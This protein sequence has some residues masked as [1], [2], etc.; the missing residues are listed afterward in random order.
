MNICL[1]FIILFSAINLIETTQLLP[2]LDIPASDIIVNVDK[3]FMLR[4]LGLYSSKLKEE[5]VHSAVPLNNL[6]VESSSTN[7]CLFVSGAISTNIVEVATILS[8]RDMVTVLPRYDTKQISGFIQ[9]DISRILQIHRSSRYTTKTSSVIHFIDNQ[10]HS[11]KNIEDSWLNSTKVLVVGD[12]S[13][14][15]GVSP[16]PPAI[17]LRQ[18]SNNKIGFDF[19]TKT[20]LT[21]FLTAIVSIIDKSYHITDLSESLNPFSQLIAAQSV[22]IL[23]SCPIR[24]EHTS[25]TNSQP[26]LIVSTLILRPLI[27]NNVVFPIYQL[28]LLPA[29][30]NGEEFMYSDLPQVIGINTND[31][32][33]I[34]WNSEP[35]KNECLFSIFVY[36]QKKLPLVRLFNLPCM[37]EQFS[38]N[39]HVASPCPI[40][41]SRKVQTNII[42]IDSNVWLFFNNE[43]PLY[44]H[45]HSNL[46][47]LNG[48]I[49]I[50][51]PSII[52]MPCGNKI[53]CANIE[54]LS[55]TCTNRSILIK[56]TATGHHHHLSTIPWSIKKMTKELVSAYKLMLKKSLKHV[57]DDLTDNRLSVM[58]TNK[59]PPQKSIFVQESPNELKFI[60]YV[61]GIM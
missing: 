35:K 3:A 34:L 29:I 33:I 55:S 17:I 45:I 40:T 53:N 41:R 42:N 9:N 23:R 32:T 46:G 36:C 19:L 2:M 6:C 18:I 57:L 49:T 16:S 20:E 7:I 31:R 44:C 25:T 4:H 38:H 52:R 15:P 51:E 21:A 43:N 59:A 39:S 12:Q 58:T 24:R 50:N 47:E 14:I 22:Y 37:S 48:I 30:V 5:I 13:R 60:G 61:G 56:S 1:Q 27:E 54:L 28:I 8:S 11:T 26:C 10:F